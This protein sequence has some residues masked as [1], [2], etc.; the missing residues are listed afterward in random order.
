MCGVAGFFADG[1]AGHPTAT[2]PMLRAMQSALA[3]RGPDG[4][5]L[6]LDP[7]GSAGLVHTRLAILDLSPAGAQPMASADG[8]RRISFNGE[9]YNFRE[10]RSQ[11][12][13]SGCRFASESDTEVILALLER[14]GPAGLRRL[15][16]MFALAYWDSETQSGLLARDGLGIKPL[17][18]AMTR[19]G[20]VFASELRT[21]LS[22]GSVP[23]ELDPSAL[24]GYFA[25]GSVPEPETLVRGVR[26]LAPGT[27]LEWNGRNSRTGTFWGVAFPEPTVEDPEDAK[28]L[29]RDALEDSMAAHLVSDVP[30]GLFLSGG[31]DSS[32]LLALAAGAGAA[33][34]MACFSVAVDDPAFD[35]ASVA[36]TT[37]AQFGV[38]HHVL[39]L[40][41]QRAGAMLADFMAAMDVPSVDG[42]NTWTVS[43]LARSHG[44]KVVLSGLGGDE[45]FGGYPSFRQIPGLLAA[46]RAL[47]RVPLLG[48]AVS[49]L[50]SRLPVGPRLRRAASLAHSDVGIADAYRAY[51]GIFSEP[52]AL[53]LAAHFSGNGE[54]ALRNGLL[55]RAHASESLPAGNQA[56]QISYLEITRYMR[57]QLL[58][59]GDVMS[60]AHGLELRLPLVDQRLFDRVA[61]VDHGLR[62][63][64]SKKLLLDA[65]PEVP[66]Q[67]RNAPKRGFSFPMRTWLANGLGPQL[68]DAARG[69][70]VR[71]TEWYQQWS[72][73]SLDHWLDARR[74]REAIPDNY[75]EMGGSTC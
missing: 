56:D 58:R 6:W 74:V 62:L 31:V 17:Y 52:D 20:L 4:R 45:L 12:Q 54:A 65:V 7:R 38:S 60:M 46:A 55:E 59:D 25:T 24:F 21:L 70:P 73:H 18:Y 40:D 57:N 67:V 69:L 28:A 51:R 39:R 27:F 22:S 30:V 41:A 10:L 23:L 61:G 26:M 3:H 33:G 66:A 9:I 50:A 15:R 14:D 19:S 49:A 72:V 11:L 42:F 13:G 8:H 53:R 35:E 37:A 16:G 48:S 29:V 32:A 2:E 34:A 44:Y 5:G 63:Q 1:V 36:A 47:G 75:S 64:P 71:A 43:S 68:Q